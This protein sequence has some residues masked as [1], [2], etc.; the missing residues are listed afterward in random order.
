MAATITPPGK[1]RIIPCPDCNGIP[2]PGLPR[3]L[4][5][6]PVYPTRLPPLRRPRLELCQR[7]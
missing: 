2:G 5:R 6:R 4:R 7:Y 1:G 3:M